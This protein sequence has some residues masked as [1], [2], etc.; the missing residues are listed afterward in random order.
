MAGRPKNYS[1]EELLAK[2]TEVFWQKGYHNAS[3]KDL[4]TAMEIGQ[5]SFYL[6][7]KGG[8]KELYQKTLKRFWKANK[9]Q[10]VQGV[11]QTENPLVFIKSFFL[12]ILDESFERCQKGCFLGNTL[13]ESSYVDEELR[14]LSI[15]L[16]QEF[17]AEFEKALKFA[18]E[19]GMLGKGKLPKV[20]A[21][22]LL[23]LWNGMNVTLRMNPNKEMAKAMIEMNLEILG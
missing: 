2:A 10:F 21:N 22:Y 15:S 9:H 20:I 23:N 1:E 19:K 3:A 17:E 13:V 4:M 18:Q 8:K 6:T 14:T 11:K 5:G 16:L 7:F 12:S